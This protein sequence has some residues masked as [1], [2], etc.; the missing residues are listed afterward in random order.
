M[1]AIINKFENEAKKRGVVL[2]KSTDVKKVKTYGGKEVDLKQV[3]FRTTLQLGEK[4]L[5]PASILFQDD[6]EKTKI[7][8]QITYSSVA[9]ISDRNKLF[10]ILQKLNELNLSKTGYYHFV[11]HS[12]GR[13]SLRNV[14]LTTID[15]EAMLE[16]FLFA[17]KLIGIL[18]MDLENMD[19]VEIMPLSDK[20]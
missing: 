8:Y 14:G 7:N 5:V 18:M 3:L 17:G 10:D 4:G 13:I 11:V 6:A 12:D 15:V 1:T 19:G 2:E 9:Q 16:T 20:L